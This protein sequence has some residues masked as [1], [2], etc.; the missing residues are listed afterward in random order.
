VQYTSEDLAPALAMLEASGRLV[1]P[2]V[3]GNTARPGWLA[4]TPQK[5]VWTT[6]EDVEPDYPEEAAAGEQAL[7]IV[8]AEMQLAN[9]FGMNDMTNRCSRDR[10]IALSIFSVITQVVRDLP[11]S[12]YHANGRENLTV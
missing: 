10:L 1:R 9:L 3:K 6:P 11:A 5:P 2:P 8:A 12:A 4:A 7:Q